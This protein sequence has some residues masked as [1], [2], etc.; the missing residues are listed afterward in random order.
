MP[1]EPVVDPALLPLPVG[2]DQDLTDPV[3]IAETRGYTPATK[4]DTED[5]MSARIC[6]KLIWC[7]VG[8][9]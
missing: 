1:H 2:G 7:M 3:S 5:V 9:R 4:R 6:Y 8:S